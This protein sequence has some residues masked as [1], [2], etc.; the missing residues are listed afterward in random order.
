M[1]KKL[2]WVCVLSFMATLNAIAQEN[3]LSVEKQ[4]QLGITA[5]TLAALKT[6][7]EVKPKANPEHP[8]LTLEKVQFA[9]AGGNRWL[10]RLDFAGEFP[11]DNSNIIFY[12]NTDNDIKTG[13][14]NYK[15]IDLMVWV[16]NG[17]TRTSFYNA[18]GSSKPGPEAFAAIDGKQLYMSI[19]IDLHQKDNE[20]LVP[21]QIVAQTNKPLKGQS[22]TP[23]FDLR[24]APVS[25]AAKA[26]RVKK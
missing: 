14:Q 6:V 12:V 3:T 15:G 16:E 21:I 5:Q 20:T 8:G 10:W 22:N 4:Q 9:N 26:D 24:G 19:D 18:A 23:F 25:T 13:R 7:Q 1:M 11:A 17:V 2:L